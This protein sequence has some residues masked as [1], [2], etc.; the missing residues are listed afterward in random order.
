MIP[1]KPVRKVS[2]ASTDMGFAKGG[3]TSRPER[4]TASS[5]G[6]KANYV[7]QAVG[8]N[9]TA[10]PMK[11]TPDGSVLTSKAQPF[12]RSGSQSMS[13]KLKGGE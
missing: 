5:Q 2:P 3:T 11:R 13:K 8:L 9:A 6:A 1:S 12:Q 4:D 7:R 10:V